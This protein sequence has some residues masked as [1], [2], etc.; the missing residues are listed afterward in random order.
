M[1]KYL[2]PL[3]LLVLVAAMALA[4]FQSFAAASPK[5]EAIGLTRAHKAA[6]RTN[7]RRHH[8]RNR[9]HMKRTRH[10]AWAKRK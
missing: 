8:R 4:P 1:K 9:R 7:H 5:V 6:V 10:A 3:T 2:A